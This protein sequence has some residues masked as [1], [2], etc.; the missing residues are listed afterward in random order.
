MLPRE[1]LSILA[2]PMDTNPEIQPLCQ[3]FL[4]GLDTV[5]GEKLAGVYLHGA[6]AFPD[7]GA[8]GDIDLH[9]VLEGELNEVEK[10]GLQDLHRAMA[11]DFA[12]LGEELDCYYILLDEARQVLPPRHQ[13]APDVFDNSWALHCEHMRAGRCIVLRGPEPRQ[14]FPAPSWSDLVDALEG[15]LDYVERHLDLYP[16]YC[17]LNLFRLI[18]SFQT[19]DVVISKRASAHWAW[20]TFPQWRAHIGAATK[21]YDHSAS[22]EDEQLLR[23]DVRDLFEFACARIQA[24]T[25]EHSPASESSPKSKY[26]LQ[27]HIR[28][29]EERMLTP[30]VRASA[31][32]LDSLLADDFIEV[33]SSGRVY[34]KQQ[35][36]AAL[37]FE[38]AETYTLNAFATRLL[39][40]DV[41][42]ATYR[43]AR[44]SQ[45]STNPEHSL[46]SSIWRYQGERWQLLFHQGTPTDSGNS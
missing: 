2:V 8:T 22:V 23:S 6:M 45:S 40:S 15:E 32:E 25:K 43:V 29:L 4:A 21:V 36:I 27:D 39:G 35:V 13:L 3:A 28:T 26:T 10:A 5:L 19:R 31:E 20:D 41:I 34:D 1:K 44:R 18:Y 42:L 30:D 16:A 33:G 14:L 24:A 37:Q 46:R 9:V 17:V 7:Q 12:P 11:R 38:R